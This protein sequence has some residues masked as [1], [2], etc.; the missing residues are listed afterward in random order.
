ML[1][2]M[3]ESAFGLRCE[4]FAVAPDPRFVYFSEPHRQA[5]AQ[6]AHGLRGGGGFV[7]LSGE[8]GAGKTT[9]WRCFLERLPANVDV[10]SIVNPK[11]GIEALLLR[12]CDDL[13]VEL[14]A[15]GRPA[16][17]V[18]AIHGH[19]LL[20]QARGRRTLVVVDEAQALAPEVLEQLRLLTNLATGL[21]PLVQVL[22]IG[23]PEL[24]DLLEHPRLEPVAQR[25]IARFHLP[26]L[27]ADDTARYVAH[28]LRV[29]GR[30][31]ELPFAPAALAR[32]HTLC[33]GVPRRINVLC[34]RALLAAHESG[35]TRV[36]RAHVERAAGEV[37]GRAARAGAAARRRAGALGALATAAG[38]LGLAV[39]AATYVPGLTE[40]LAPSPAKR[41][42]PSAATP[43]IAPPGGDANDAVLPAPA[44]G[45]A[46][47]AA[48]PA[49]AP[50]AASA[51]DSPSPAA[52]EPAPDLAAL[53][54]LAPADESGAWHALA[55]LWGAPLGPGDPCE[56]ARAQGLRCHRT[57]GGLAPI[58]QLGRPGWVS[59]VDP[60]GRATPL[61]LVGL[62][63]DS[64]TL[65]AGGREQR[66]SLAQLAR[67]WRGEFA[68]LWRAPPGYRDG[69]F[70]GPASALAPWLADRLAAVEARAPEPPGAAS[71]TA[72]RIYA[73][74]LAQGL[75]PDGL[76]GPLTLMQL[77][78]ASGVAEPRLALHR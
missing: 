27:A 53:V 49:V 72:D 32:V 28:R 66:V 18:D 70:V 57:Q 1:G 7:L 42:G 3:Y 56:A 77:N 74:Q 20:A 36:D 25:V 45:A 38:L 54:A 16:D 23:Q 12:I 37:F 34:D 60:S 2:A 39:F 21:H 51:P 48:A 46:M 14:P 67:L 44:G 61:L 73:F 4:P 69:E 52:P 76:A 41:S 11:L 50:A 24:R 17:L 63:D 35:S 71:G 64:A 13:R 6:L 58:R 33:S 5:L 31:G 55:R 22:L 59:V 43:A 65:A 68:T 62:G 26:A 9:L 29:A 75:V 19:L 78:R 40:A 10:A 8:I 30:T 47:A 15:D